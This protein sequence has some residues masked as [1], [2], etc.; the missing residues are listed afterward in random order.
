MAKIFKLSPEDIDWEVEGLAASGEVDSDGVHFGLSERHK[1]IMDLEKALR[2][3][4][5]RLAA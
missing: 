5:I 4:P 2:E 1:K 3:S